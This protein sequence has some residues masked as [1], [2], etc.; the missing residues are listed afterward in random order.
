MPI[1]YAKGRSAR[2]SNPSSLAFHLI[3]ATGILSP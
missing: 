2:L 1:P 3:A